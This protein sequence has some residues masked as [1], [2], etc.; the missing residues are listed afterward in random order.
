MTTRRDLLKSGALL[1]IAGLLAA[2]RDGWAAE[3]R[4]RF[5]VDG[6][7]PE[8]EHLRRHAKL[9]AHQCV[10]PKGEIIAFLTSHPNWIADT[11]PVIGL[12]GYVDH[13]LARDVFRT[14]G[15]RLRHVWQLG[16]SPGPEPAQTSDRRRSLLATLLGSPTAH[17]RLGPT[18]FLW[19]A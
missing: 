3:T 12:T 2:P 1:P 4:P 9:S 19:I 17:A 16:P 14:A 13:A 5:L 11:A 10:D 15:R 6:R 8:A 7:L 18:S